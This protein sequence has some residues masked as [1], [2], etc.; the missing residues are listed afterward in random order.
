M[1]EPSFEL[2]E[3]ATPYA[4]HAVS[5]TERANIE[6]QVA[7]AP[8]PVAEAFDDEVATV[9]ETIAAVSAATAAQPPA[10]LRASILA[11]ARLNALRY[12]R[13]RTVALAAAAAAAVGLTAFGA[14]I[15]MQPSPAPTIAE[16]VLRA[17]D[18]RTV[19]TPIPTGG[20]ATVMF[21]RDK[22]AGVLVMNNV[23]APPPGTVY[24]M[25]L[26]DNHK[27]TSAGTMAAKTVA[28]S[29]T[30]VVSDLG[31]SSALAFTVEPGSGS[32]QPTGTIF[33]QLPLS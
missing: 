22:N 25:W 6:R 19:S 5:E 18:V 3:L 30:A 1:T 10:H 26:L 24:Q 32:P 15:A 28:Q 8:A 13:W 31:K 23:A 33:S 16:Q 4:L 11:A 2:L 14:G 27:P 21:S 20:T 7:A 29:T 17:S 9:R 12:S